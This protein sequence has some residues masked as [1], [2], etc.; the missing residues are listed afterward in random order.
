M[1]WPHG[2]G[3]C[4]H[5]CFLLLDLLMQ[6][7]ASSRA[8]SVTFTLHTTANSAEK[9]MCIPLNQTLWMTLHRH[10]HA[11]LGEH[12]CWWF[13]CS[14]VQQG[15]QLFLHVCCAQR[16]QLQP[17]Q[18]ACVW[19]FSQAAAR[20]NNNAPQ[21]NGVFQCLINCHRSLPVTH[22]STDVQPFMIGESMVPVLLAERWS[23]VSQSWFRTC[24][25][26]ALWE[27][28]FA[29]THS[30]WF[31]TTHWFIVCRQCWHSSLPA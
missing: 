6:C 18:T 12:W 23:A 21:S 13:V 9:C 7:I 24:A 30:K 17:A 11:Q 20:S 8:V 26:T 19:P 14:F 5:P 22:P 27:I 25:S 28:S 10:L 1:L 16:R 29:A 2:L 31:S 15:G 3:R 4:C